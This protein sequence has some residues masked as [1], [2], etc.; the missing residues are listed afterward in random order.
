MGRS[1]KLTITLPNSMIKQID[2]ERG[3]IS[4]SRFILRLI[5]VSSRFKKEKVIQR[6][7]NF[8]PSGVKL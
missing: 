2:L 7:L 6:K 1:Q 4:R 3:D 5:E 8:A